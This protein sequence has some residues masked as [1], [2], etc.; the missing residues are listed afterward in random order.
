MVKKILA[1]FQFNRNKKIDNRG[2]TMV[3]VII[4]FALLLLF[5]TSYFKVQKLSMEMMM[6]SR[7]MMVNNSQLIK[8]YY[9]GE[10]E[11]K[12][13]AENVSFNFSGQEGSFY[14]QGTLKSAVQD[15]LNGTIYYF[16]ADTR[17]P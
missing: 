3:T 15:G 1:R 12:T 2:T 10:T 11:D 16:D 14:V 4:S 13:V 7:D 6:N 5:V 8:A 17:E 9:L